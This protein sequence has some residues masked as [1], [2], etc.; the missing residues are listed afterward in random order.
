MV[1]QENGLSNNYLGTPVPNPERKGK[2][3]GQE[4]LEGVL[5]ESRV[6]NTPKPYKVTGPLSVISVV[7]SVSETGLS[8]KSTIKRFLEIPL[9]IE[10]LYVSVINQ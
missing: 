8:S 9:T 7:V 6:L 3:E 5:F 1:D 10:D 4:G 2:D